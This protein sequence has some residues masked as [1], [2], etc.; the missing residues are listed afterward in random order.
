MN[1]LDISRQE[2]F[3]ITKDPVSEHQLYNCKL[4]LNTFGSYS[5]TIIHNPVIFN[6][7]IGKL[8]VLR[9]SWYDINGNLID[10]AECDWSASFQIVERVDIATDDSTAVQSKYL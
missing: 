2:D 6:P 8:D 1:R 9:F 7:P 4:L 3:S 10:N 5:M